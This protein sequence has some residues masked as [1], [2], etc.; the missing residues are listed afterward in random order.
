MVI[1]TVSEDYATGQIICT[2]WR[3]HLFL[4]RITNYI[5]ITTGV[6]FQMP[7]YP[8]RE[9]RFLFRQNNGGE[10]GMEDGCYQS[11]SSN[12]I[13]QTVQSITIPLSCRVQENNLHAA[14]VQYNDYLVQ[15]RPGLWKPSF[16][17]SCH[18]N[19]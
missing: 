10:D 15:N 16:Y 5:V 11:S 3:S 19:H 18:H 13:W 1:M 7:R 2:Q 6:I 14:T 17:K 8:S 4:R 12:S 9:K